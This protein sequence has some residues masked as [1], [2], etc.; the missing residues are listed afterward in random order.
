MPEGGMLSITTENVGSSHVQ[1][2]VEDTGQGLAPDVI[3]RVFEP[4]FTTKANH[5]GS[6]LGLSVAQGIVRQSGGTLTA[7]NASRGGARFVF[8]LPA[9]ED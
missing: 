1:V 3:D 8:T 7:H 4:F 5:S 2:V 9:S 6:G